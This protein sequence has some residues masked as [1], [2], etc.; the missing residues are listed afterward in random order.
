VHLG[1]ILV[2][3]QF[4]AQFFFV[5][6]YFYSVHISDSHVPIIRRINCINTT[7][8]ICHSKKSKRIPSIFNDKSTRSY[9]SYATHIHVTRIAAMHIIFYA[10]MQKPSERSQM[11][12]HVT[13]RDIHSFPS[14]YHVMRAHTSECDRSAYR[15]SYGAVRDLEE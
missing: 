2:N 8:G 5:Y 14:P 3:N 11:R 9:I 7:S 4:D 6:V 13:M 15:Q 10:Y 12:Q 1:I